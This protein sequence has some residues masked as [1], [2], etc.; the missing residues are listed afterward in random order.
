ME[1][2]ICRRIL[3]SIFFLSK[4]EETFKNIFIHK[5]K[6]IFLIISVEKHEIKMLLKYFLFIPMNIYNFYLFYYNFGLY[7]IPKLEH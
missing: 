7:H 6:D 1:I 5:M 4:F 2:C 3:Y